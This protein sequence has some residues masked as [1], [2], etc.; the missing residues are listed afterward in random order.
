MRFDEL[1]VMFLGEDDFAADGF[2]GFLLADDAAGDVLC[3]LAIV[4]AFHVEIGLQE[5]DQFDGA[6][7]VVDRDEVDAFEHRDGLGAERF[8]EDGAARAFVDETVGGDG[9]DEDIAELA[10]LLEVAEVAD[11]D[12]IEHTVAMGDLLSRQA[13]FL[14]RG[15]GFLDSP[16]FLGGHHEPGA[17]SLEDT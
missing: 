2:H 5:G 11:V 1:N 8:G 7:P 6:G 3:G 12:E 16:Y 9:D 17:V 10:G 15:G 4:G 14:Q 13:Q